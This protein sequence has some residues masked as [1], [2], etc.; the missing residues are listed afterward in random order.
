HYG[1]PDQKYLRTMTLS[2]AEKYLKEGHFPAGS[3]EP[4]IEAAGEF[5]RCGGKRA[6]ICSIKNIEKALAGKAGTEIVRA[7]QDS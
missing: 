1:R 3:M 6:V 2:D 4:K 7:V 5:L